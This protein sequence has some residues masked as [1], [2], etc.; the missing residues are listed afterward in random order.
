MSRVEL[1][2]GVADSLEYPCLAGPGR[3]MQDMSDKTVR[4]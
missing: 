2:T 3:R 4:S 1:S